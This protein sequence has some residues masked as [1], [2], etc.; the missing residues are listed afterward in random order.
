MYRYLLKIIS[1]MQG[2]PSRSEITNSHVPR[3]NQTPINADKEIDLQWFASDTVLT[4]EII[5]EKLN[6]EPNKIEKIETNDVAKLTKVFLNEGQNIQLTDNVSAVVAEPFYVDQTGSPVGKITLERGLKANQADGRIVLTDVDGET[7]LTD[8]VRIKD[9]VV[10]SE[11]LP[12]TALTQKQV[13]AAKLSAI[14]Q[15]TVGDVLNKLSNIIPDKTAVPEQAVVT[16]ELKLSGGGTITIDLPN[17]QAQGDTGKVVI[18]KDIKDLL[19]VTVPGNEKPLSLLEFTATPNVAQYSFRLPDGT[20]NRLAIIPT[21]QGLRAQLLNPYTPISVSF[22][23]K[24][25]TVITSVKLSEKNIPEFHVKLLDADRQPLSLTAGQPTKKDNLVYD[26]DPSQTGG[27]NYQLVFDASGTPIIQVK[28]NGKIQDIFNNIF[29]IIRPNKDNSDKAV[30]TATTTTTTEKQPGK[31]VSEKVIINTAGSTQAV[32][33]ETDKTK[34]AALENTQDKEPGLGQSKEE[35]KKTSENKNEHKDEQPNQEKTPVHTEA[36]THRDS[37][38]VPQID[39]NTLAESNETTIDDVKLKAYKQTA[40]ALDGKTKPQMNTLIGG[41]GLLGRLRQGHL[42]SAP[43]NHINMRA[44]NFALHRVPAVVWFFQSRLIAL[45]A[46]SARAITHPRAVLSLIAEAITIGNMPAVSIAMFY[47]GSL[48]AA[49]PWLGGLLLMTV[50]LGAMEYF[51]RGMDGYTRLG[52]M[53]RFAGHNPLKRTA[54]M[55]AH[56]ATYL[57][58]VFSAQTMTVRGGEIFDRDYLD[59]FVDTDGD[60]RAHGKY[61]TLHRNKNGSVS[62]DFSHA[63]DLKDADNFMFILENAI[64]KIVNTQIDRAPLIARKLDIEKAISQLSEAQRN[65]YIKQLNRLD[66]KKINN[67]NTNLILS[68]KTEAQINEYEEE[69][70]KIPEGMEESRSQYEAYVKLKFELDYIT[71]SKDKERKEEYR[72]QLAAFEEENKSLIELRNLAVMSRDIAKLSRAGRDEISIANRKYLDLN[73]E[74]TRKKG[75]SKE[76]LNLAKLGLEN[77]PGIYVHNKFGREVLQINYHLRRETLETKVVP[78]LRRLDYTE[79]SIEKVMIAYKIVERLYHA[80]AAAQP[81]YEENVDTRIKSVADITPFSPMPY[82]V[83]INEGSVR[84][85]YLFNSRINSVFNIINNGNKAHSD[86]Q[87]RGQGAIGRGTEARYHALTDFVTSHGA[88]GDA[89]KLAEQVIAGG[90]QTKAEKAEA[91]DAILNTYFAVNTNN[92]KRKEAIIR[93]L[94][95]VQKDELEHPDNKVTTDIK[96][97]LLYV[98]LMNGFDHNTEADPRSANFY[99]LLYQLVDANGRMELPNIVLDETLTLAFPADGLERNE[100]LKGLNRAKLYAYIRGESSANPV[101][102]DYK[103]G[104]LQSPKY[105]QKHHGKRLSVSG[106]KTD[107]T[108]KIKITADD[109]EWVTLEQFLKDDLLPREDTCLSA[110]MIENYVRLFNQALDTRIRNVSMQDTKGNEKKAVQSKLMAQLAAKYSRGE[111]LD[112]EDIHDQKN[113]LT[114]RYAIDEQAAVHLLDLMNHKGINEKTD[115]HAEINKNALTYAAAYLGGNKIGNVEAI[116]DV[117][118]AEFLQAMVYQKSIEINENSAN[119]AF[120]MSGLE[121]RKGLNYVDPEFEAEFLAELENLFKADVTEQELAD[122]IE[123]ILKGNMSEE[124]L[125]KKSEFEQREILRFDAK[126]MDLLKSKLETLSEG[127]FNNHPELKDWLAARIANPKNYPNK[128]AALFEAMTVRDMGSLAV[129]KDIIAKFAGS[130][131]GTREI[132]R[133]V[134]DKYLRE[135]YC[136]EQ[137]LKNKNNDVYTLHTS[138]HNLIRQ[139]TTVSIDLSQETQEILKKYKKY[140]ITYQDGKLTYMTNSVGFSKFRAENLPYEEQLALKELYLKQLNVNYDVTEDAEALLELKNTIRLRDAALSIYETHRFDYHRILGEMKKI[141]TPGLTSYQRYQQ[142]IARDHAAVLED[143]KGAFKKINTEY[144]GKIFPDNPQTVS[145][146]EQIEDLAERLVEL[147]DKAEYL[148]QS[149]TM[150]L[151]QQG[152]AIVLEAVKAHDQTVFKAGSDISDLAKKA[153]ARVTAVREKSIPSNGIKIDDLEEKAKAEREVF[154]MFK[155]FLAGFGK[156]KKVNFPGAFWQVPMELAAKRLGVCT[157]LAME[158]KDKYKSNKHLGFYSAEFGKYF[159]VEGGGEGQM[160]FNDGKGRNAYVSI[161]SLNEKIGKA[162]DVALP[163]LIQL[164]GMFFQPGHQISVGLSTAAVDIA[165]VL[166]F[167]DLEISF[168]LPLGLIFW[169]LIYE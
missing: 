141:K 95:R 21:A 97:A 73:R 17:I 123:W 47:A 24:E 117:S 99:A 160:Y 75:S 161:A 64:I 81:I 42:F 40:S 137:R 10:R 126:Q 164:T 165:Q 57:D 12:D 78:E 104:P 130:K 138:V 108:T 38:D 119:L 35:K 70:A 103:H 80:D 62:G 54:T 118:D 31:A 25:F 48:T 122:V 22:D 153:R 39:K 100:M 34:L 43:A 84:G 124:D 156:N 66:R 69:L 26:L 55:S 28:Q 71:K 23:D 155:G 91:V 90:L 136:I 36:I 9:G 27:K 83:V 105:G 30:T 19:V 14:I 107:G 37:H 132:W 143:L 79:D 72:K 77:D 4:K 60:A 158:L 128:E 121:T 154:D 44:E 2:P 76:E 120:S 88:V 115:N 63:V 20:S 18:P 135:L 145:T 112:A 68:D 92:E 41:F 93:V 89:V 148:Q 163:L 106:Y 157:A 101:Y 149:T 109:K 166:E 168:Q 33:V 61:F 50:F 46:W 6:I 150:G 29:T 144:G 139:K 11:L 56:T 96:N 147:L 140:G 15:R 49:L 87:A 53:V 82:G 94:N 167:S 86:S 134:I 51:R 125:E 151:Y 5:A 131:G 74:L 13:P 59:R 3:D 58:E 45:G 114:A 102:I 142:V 32:A 67:Y 127:Y 169:I 152:N 16:Q 65:D 1:D 116:A 162:Q 133:Q 52:H 113:C 8:V 146:A 129:A 85:E 159:G 110:E 98:I 111:E 7:F